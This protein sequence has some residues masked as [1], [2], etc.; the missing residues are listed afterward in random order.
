MHRALIV[1]SIVGVGFASGCSSSTSVTATSPSGTKCAISATSSLSSF[2]PSGG[3]GSIVITSARECP[4]AISA[5]TP[6][7]VPGQTSGQGDAT[8]PFRVAANGTPQARR[9]ALTIAAARVDVAQE[10]APCR[11]D[12]DTTH[13][14]VAASGG[15]L[16]IAVTAMTGCAWTA[17][18]LDSW[19]NIIGGASAGGSGVIQLSI[20]ANGGAARQGT[21]SVANQAIL[22][23]QRGATS[24]GGGGPNPSRAGKSFTG[25]AGRTG[26]ASVGVTRRLP[27]RDIHAVRVD[28]LCGWC[29]RL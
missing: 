10:G 4:W 11:F 14:D 2:P 17:R 12:L 28:G 18:A 6:W 9:G 25:R 19:I 26:R 1:S 5:D 7:I 15:D 16:R 20:A 22:V 8:L 24:P 27:E 23:A 3:S 29:H 13:A 21:V